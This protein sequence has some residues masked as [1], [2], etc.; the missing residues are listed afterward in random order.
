MFT[1]IPG[2]KHISAK[3]ARPVE[4]VRASLLPAPRCAIVV[5]REDLG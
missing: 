1:A 2:T 4:R 5:E 3:G